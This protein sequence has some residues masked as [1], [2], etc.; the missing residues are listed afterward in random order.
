MLK[1]WVKTGS[2]KGRLLPWYKGF[3]G[4]IAPKEAV[5]GE[6]SNSYDV[7]GI[8]KRTAPNQIE[9][10][11]LPIRKWTQ[12]YKEFL[13][14]LADE[15]GNGAQVEDFKEYHTENTVH[16]TLGGSVTQMKALE[17]EGF[18][19]S[20]K[21][22][23][24]LPASNIVLFDAE[25]KVKKYGCEADV[26]MEFAELRLK[27]YQKRKDFMVDRLSREREW[28]DSKV[29]F[30]LLVVKG[31]L[32]VGNR[33]RQE[34][35]ADLQKRG[36]KSYQ[37]IFDRA[38][39]A[40]EGEAGDGAAAA[41]GGRSGFDYLLGM[42]L[43]S[44]TTEKVE[45]LKRQSKEKQEELMSLEG[46]TIQEL[47]LRDLDA[48]LAEL[49]AI[50]ELDKEQSR[51]DERLRSGKRARP[52]ASP[53][54]GRGGRG[55]AR[56]GG[57]QDDADDGGD[58][59][60]YE[61]IGEYLMP[62]SLRR[63]EFRKAITMAQSVHG[64]A[65]DA[66]YMLVSWN[67]ETR[68]QAIMRERLWIAVL[69]AIAL[70][71]ALSAAAVLTEKACSQGD[72]HGLRYTIRA[73]LNGMTPEIA[74]LLQRPARYTRT[75]Q[76]VLMLGFTLP[77]LT[78]VLCVTMFSFAP[79]FY[80]GNFVKAFVLAALGGAIVTMI[81]KPR[82]FEFGVLLLTCV[83]VGST[84][85]RWNFSQNSFHFCGI[86]THKAY[87]GVQADASQA[88][89]SDAGKIYFSQNSSIDVD[90]SI[91]FVYDEVTYCAAPILPSAAAP[92]APAALFSKRHQGRAS[93][94]TDL[95]VDRAISREEAVPAAPAFVDFWAVGRD[96]C[97]A[98][99]GFKCFKDG[100]LNANSGVV[101]RDSS[102]HGL[103]D[104]MHRGFLLAVAAAADN[105]D[106]P[107]PVTPML[108]EWGH[109]LNA[110]KRKWLTHAISVIL[111]T[112][113]CSFILFAITS[114]IR[115]C[116]GP[117]RGSADSADDGL[118]G[119]LPGSMDATADFGQRAVKPKKPVEA[120]APPR[121]PPIAYTAK[122]HRGGR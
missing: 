66:G 114:F 30:I 105:Y 118:R 18:E 95:A 88:R 3:K 107:V 60:L 53:K 57:K 5:D 54:A 48:V 83:I 20:L 78:M 21:L 96:C 28:L 64:V 27:Y 61:M 73:V 9:I 104:D 42:P 84:I 12:D 58:D 122:G 13:A 102:E 55:K 109:N 65:A 15:S 45:E 71:Y 77:V 115:P 79:C 121:K 117:R 76:E 91:G 99:G 62:A 14:K 11:E 46:T 35:L 74:E 50:E 103:F 22:K 19:K 120:A 7:M 87:A 116:S 110:L 31:E 8:A 40:E 37:Q 6:E 81:M 63:D 101:L 51:E 89:Y 16:F 108:I 52:K 70:I 38:G 39:D 43:W 44:L 112:S 111:F 68:E 1:E 17:Q 85:G 97:D 59:R 113:A 119:V 36:F 49:D 2:I 86:Y 4:S 34:L 94:A 75:A 26:L 47:W 24:S 32:V 41:K 67:G 69:L 98:R 82:I 92:A 100:E 10:T 93:Q 106:L 80:W 33:K 23:S 72:E 29:R 25:G 56:G 90:K